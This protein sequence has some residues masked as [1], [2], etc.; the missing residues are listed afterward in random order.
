ME[1]HDKIQFKQSGRRAALQICILTLFLFSN[2][3]LLLLKQALLPYL[4]K[5]NQTAMREVKLKQP[6]PGI[7]LTHF[8]SCYHLLPFFSAFLFFQPF[9]FMSPPSHET[10]AGQQ[11]SPHKEIFVFKIWLEK[12]KPTLNFCFSSNSSW[13]KLFQTTPLL[14]S[15]S[16]HFPQEFYPLF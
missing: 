13:L 10:L 5:K 2:K 7:T 16:D 11:T 9:L 8:S 12:P 1:T 14:S 15:P 4:L 6:A 3:A